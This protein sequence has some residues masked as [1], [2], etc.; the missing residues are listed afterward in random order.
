M[1][2]YCGYKG[3]LST[4]QAFTTELMVIYQDKH[5]MRKYNTPSEG[6]LDSGSELILI[7]KDLKY[8]HRPQIISFRDLWK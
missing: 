5:V 8:H 7:P 4:L 2:L 6:L 3:T 1:I